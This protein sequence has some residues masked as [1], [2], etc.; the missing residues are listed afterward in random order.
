MSNTKSHAGTPILD[1]SQPL[2][3]CSLS[4]LYNASKDWGLFHIINYGISKDLCS[5][6]QTLSKHLFTLPSKTKLRLG[7]LSSLNSYTPLFI[8]SPFFE[9]LRVNGPNFYVSADNFCWD[10]LWQKGLQIQ[11]INQC[12]WA[13]LAILVFLVCIIW[14]RSQLYI[15]DN[16]F[17]KHL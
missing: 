9:S 13:F 10:P 6:I 5:Q 14:F 12:L 11:V 2:Q 17:L 4:S 7:P 3:P 1:L 16:F 15:L 8:A